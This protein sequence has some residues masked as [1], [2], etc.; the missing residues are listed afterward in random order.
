MESTPTSP[1]LVSVV[2]LPQYSRILIMADGL[3]RDVN[4]NVDASAAVVAAVK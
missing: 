4:Q 2:A 3:V 1:P